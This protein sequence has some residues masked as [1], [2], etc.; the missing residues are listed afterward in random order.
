MRAMKKKKNGFISATKIAQRSY[1]EKQIVLDQQYGRNETDVQRQR[2]ERGEEE[3][4]RHHLEAQRYGAKRDSRCFIATE[5][6][7]PL[8]KE[9]DQ[10]RQF[11]DT[12]LMSRLWGRIF[13]R[14]Y[15]E[16]SP[17]IVRLMK[18]YPMVR[19][20]IKPFINWVVRM[21]LSLIHISEP[22]RPY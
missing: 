6:F 12:F 13:T 14:A 9:T 20:L 22:T 17:S 1:C 3:H 7:G 15:Y 21:V 16:V 4:L 5:L 18:K 10:L 8:A 19:S 11:R 2:R